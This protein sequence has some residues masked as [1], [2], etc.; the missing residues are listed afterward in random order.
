VEI[1]S[2]LTALNNNAIFWQ[3]IH[4]KLQER[5][6][7]RNYN[8][9]IDIPE[10]VIPDCVEELNDIVREKVFLH[11]KRKASLYAYRK[12]CVR[13]FHAEKGET[14][15]K[16]NLRMS[17]VPLGAVNH[18]LHTHPFCQKIDFRGKKGRYY[19]KKLA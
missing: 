10:Y 11:L 16:E 15:T 6:P 3:F 5:F 7:T 13:H 17:R 19:R 14:A 18:R 8:R 12:G 4:F 1:D 2:V 9:A